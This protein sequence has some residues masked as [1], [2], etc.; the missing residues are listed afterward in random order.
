MIQK[1]KNFTRSKKLLK[2]LLFLEN[3]K[4][5]LRKKYFIIFILRIV[6]R[7]N[8][9]MTYFLLKPLMNDIIYIY[10]RKKM[11]K[12]IQRWKACVKLY[13]RR[14]ILVLNFILKLVNNYAFKPFIKQLKRKIYEEG[15]IE[16]L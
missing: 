6:E 1:W 3:I 16:E 14:D 11:E 12:I 2:S 9:M 4:F 7:I 8:S 10:Y 15:E 13:R 5:I